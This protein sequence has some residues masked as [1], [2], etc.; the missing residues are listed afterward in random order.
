MSIELFELKGSRAGK[1]L[2]YADSKRYEDLVDVFELYRSKTG[3]FIDKYRDTKLSSGL[4]VLIECVQ[5]V[6]ASSSSSSSSSKVREEFLAVLVTADAEG[7][8]VI[9]LGE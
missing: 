4:S 8:N 9:F 6:M 5:E 3:I 2:F 7:K 1:F